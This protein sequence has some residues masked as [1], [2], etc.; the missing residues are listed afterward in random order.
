MGK[1][2]EKQHLVANIDS[3]IKEACEL[4]EFAFDALDSRIG[5]SLVNNWPS[6]NLRKHLLDTPSLKI[7]PD[8]GAT[9]KKNRNYFQQNGDW[10]SHT[11]FL[12]DAT[13]NYFGGIN[14]QGSKNYWFLVIDSCEEGNSFRCAVIGSS[15]SDL[16]SSGL[17]IE[18]YYLVLD[19]GEFQLA[20]DN[21]KNF[22]ALKN[23][24]TIYT[25]S[26][27]LIG[28]WQQQIE[29]A[30]KSCRYTDTGIGAN[31]KL[32]SSSDNI[33]MIDIMRPK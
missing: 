6:A 32:S 19:S 29:M 17:K 14:Y 31:L 15:P 23:S 3:T 33:K 2:R 11:Y 4:Y 18:S 13:L 12:R 10:Q 22:L 30:N 9:P 7:I 25:L 26:K 1:K 27:E 28:A 24:C 16:I 8:I 21:F 5:K 20:K